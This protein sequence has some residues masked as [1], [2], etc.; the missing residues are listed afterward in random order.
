MNAITGAVSVTGAASVGEGRRPAATMEPDAPGSPV[1]RGRVAVV[2]GVS[3]RRGIGFAVARRMAALGADFFLHSFVPLDAQQP[4]GQPEDAARL[5]CWLA[6][7][8]ARWVTGQTIN[9]TGGA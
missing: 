2:T 1:L 8:D 5:I 6:S 9:S 7:E 3:R 4:W